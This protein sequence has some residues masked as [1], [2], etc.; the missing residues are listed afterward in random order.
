ML[1]ERLSVSLSLLAA[2][3]ITYLGFVHHWGFETIMVGVLVSVVVMLFIGRILGVMSA[4][5]LAKNI[6]E[7]HKDMMNTEE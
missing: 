6:Q 2:I 7:T 4:R 3:A 5:E 1:P